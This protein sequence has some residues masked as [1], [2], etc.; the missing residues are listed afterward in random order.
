MVLWFLPEGLRRYDRDTCVDVCIY[1][2]V[3]GCAYVCVCVWRGF[4]SFR[5]W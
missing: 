2:C 1:V 5:S 3:C 4:E